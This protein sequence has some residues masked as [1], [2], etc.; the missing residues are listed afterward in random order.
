MKYSRGYRP[1]PFPRKEKKKSFRKSK[2]IF[3]WVL[4]LVLV[5][6]YVLFLSP[7][8]EIKEINTSGNRIISNH[9]IQNALAEQ[10]NIFLATNNKLKNILFDNFPIIASVVINKNIFKKSINL[11]IVERKEVGI[12]CGKECYYIDKN[13]II[14]EKAPQTSGALILVINDYSNREIEIGSK[15][16]SEKLIADFI[17]TSDYLATQLNLKA[18]EFVFEMGPSGDLK[19]NTNEGW[20]ILLDMSR[21]FKNQLQ[22]LEL[23]LGEKIK[24]RS[25]LEY[26]DLR[27]ENRVY[28]K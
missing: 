9:E 24:D 15:V 10:N 23:V 14:F 2:I 25:S 5:L 6:A 1:R 20:Y 26:V 18:L 7:I 8:F 28:Y 12:F 22:A 21:N 3:A 27:I 17:E 13:G 4:F 19:I 11:K 16:L